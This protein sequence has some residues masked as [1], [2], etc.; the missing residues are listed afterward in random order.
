[1]R[2][3]KSIKI[4]ALTMGLLLVTGNVL[5][6]EEYLGATFRLPLDVYQQLYSQANKPAKEELQ[7]P[8]SV[9]FVPAPNVA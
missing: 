4:L 5:A 9:G 8:V 7:P 6:E 1:M 2:A 3:V